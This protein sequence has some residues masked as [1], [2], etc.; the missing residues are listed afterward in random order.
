MPI[1]H[2]VTRGIPPRCRQLNWWTPI[3]EFVSESSMNF[4]PRY[5][6][7]GVDNGFKRLQLLRVEQNGSASAAKHIHKDGRKQAKGAD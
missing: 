7:E 6:D 5:F 1:R 3:F 4:L 2:T